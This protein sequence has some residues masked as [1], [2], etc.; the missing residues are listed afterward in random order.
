VTGIEF[1][2]GFIAGEGSL[3]V[4]TKKASNGK[5]YCRPYL[6]VG[7]DKKDESVL[8]KIKSTFDNAG[9]VRKKRGGEVVAWE[10]ESSKDLEKF[11]GIIDNHEPS[12]GWLVSEK[13]ETYETWKKIVRIYTK[14]KQTNDQERVNMLSIAEKEGLNFGAG[15]QEKDY[16]SIIDWYEENQNVY[17]NVDTN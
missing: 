9:R 2:L 6:K 14:K 17:P 5:W 3:G 15:R 8:W 16:Q 10:I 11:I 7:L 1:A 4:N 13:R 12:I